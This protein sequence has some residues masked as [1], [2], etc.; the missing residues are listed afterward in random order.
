QPQGDRQADTE[1][2]VDAPLRYGHGRGY[3][4]AYSYTGYYQGNPVG[5]SAYMEWVDTQL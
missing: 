3:V 4:G 2:V 5:G 1:G